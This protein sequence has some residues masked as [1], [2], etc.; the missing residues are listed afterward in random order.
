MFQPVRLKFVA[1]SA[2][3]KHP[4]A[5]SAMSSSSATAASSS[6][7]CNP[8]PAKLAKRMGHAK[9]P[10]TPPPAKTGVAAAGPPVKA[11]LLVPRLPLPPAKAKLATRE[12]AGRAPE[13]EV[14]VISESRPA[15]AKAT[16]VAKAK[17]RD[18]AIRKLQVELGQAL[19][20]IDS[21]ERSA[22]EDTNRVNDELDN[23]DAR[24]AT[25][26]E[27]SPM[28][29]PGPA[30]AQPATPGQLATPEL[31]AF[32]NLR[33]KIAASIRYSAVK[34]DG[35]PMVVYE[36]SKFGC[37][38]WADIEEVAKALGMQPWT[39]LEW[40]TDPSVGAIQ[41]HVR[42]KVQLYM[43]RDA[44]DRI[45]L[46]A[47][48]MDEKATLANG[49]AN[50]TIMGRYMDVLTRPLS[51]ADLLA[52]GAEHYRGVK[53]AIY[54]NSLGQR[55]VIHQA[56]NVLEAK[57]A[58]P[59]APGYIGQAKQGGVGGARVPPPPRPPLPAATL[60]TRSGGVQQ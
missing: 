4:Q 36:A 42:V 45:L 29:D 1:T 10:D 46:G 19:A 13:D 3:A 20:R 32:Q 33:D 50:P 9:Q 21:L 2:S 12:P 39:L 37:T 6:A 24:L 16:A 43:R 49:E 52:I 58:A 44:P 22:A 30:N 23:L 59:R 56:G 31:V 40:V 54:I 53:H 8:P 35:R 48:D 26:E 5:L 38:R 18:N 55:M 34:P 17:S 28:E 14:L 27:D 25:L 15:A 51:P 60:A 47:T 41:G 11:G 57:A 7:K